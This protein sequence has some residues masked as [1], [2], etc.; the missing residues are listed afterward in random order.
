MINGHNYYSHAVFNV[1]RI[2]KQAGNTTLRTKSWEP[3][4][5]N[6]AAKTSFQCLTQGKKKYLSSK[7]FL[8]TVISN[9]C[10]GTVEIFWAKVY[11]SQRKSDNF[12]HYLLNSPKKWY[13]I[14]S[15]HWDTRTPQER[16]KSCWLEQWSV[17]KCRKKKGLLNHN[18]QSS[19]RK[20]GM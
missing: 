4:K 10:I 18:S 13:T 12:N 14:S 15:A 5:S 20:I 16:Y 1:R 2:C 11:Y 19:R 9:E 17:R 6:S 3:F 8:A 7:I